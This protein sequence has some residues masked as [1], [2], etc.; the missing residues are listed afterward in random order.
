MSTVPPSYGSNLPATTLDSLMG[1][2]EEEEG[3]GALNLPG[4]LYMDSV[5][6]PTIGYGF[7]L[8]QKNSL[9]A[10]L[11]V[12]QGSFTVKGVTTTGNVFSA[13]AAFA[14]ASSVAVPSTSAIVNYFYW[15][16]H[17]YPSNPSVN[18]LG[19][20]QTQLDNALQDFFT[21]AR[22]D[23][24][25]VNGAPQL[26]APPTA[27]SGVVFEFSNTDFS[28]A[29][30]VLTELIE[31][32]SIPEQTS[33]ALGVTGVSPALWAA[34]AN[35][36]APLDTNQNIIGAGP[37]S[38]QWI[39][40]VLAAYN[41]F[42]LHASDG[43][44]NM[45]PAQSWYSLRYTDN[46]L[47]TSGVA[48]RDYIEST[49][50]GLNGNQSAITYNLALQDYQ[51][52]AQHR[53]TIIPFEQKWGV[54]PDGT[55]PLSVPVAGTAMA[56]ADGDISSIGTSVFTSELATV[57][58]SLT[59]QQVQTLAQ[60][61]N[62]AAEQV[63][64]ELGALYPSIL[65]N[66][67]I[68]GDGPSGAFNVRSTDIFI[69]GPSSLVVNASLGDV[70]P[71]TPT[72]SLAGSFAEASS[73]HILL[74]TGS[75]DTLIGGF[76][77]DILIADTG[78]ETLTSGLGSDTIIA[79]AGTDIVNLR[80]VAST[81]DFE[82]QGQT[83]LNETINAGSFS[84]GAVDVGGTRLTGS[85]GAPTAM[86][87]SPT[88]R[89]DLTWTDAG[90]QTYI[91]DEATHSLGISGGLLGS[92]TSG[93]SITI[94][95]F[96]LAAAEGLGFLGITLAKRV[97]L[98]CGTTSGATS[99][100]EPLP[101][102]FRA[103]S[104]QTYTLST[105][106]ASDAAQTV[107]LTLSGMNPADFRAIVDNQTVQQN[108]DGTFTFVLPAGQTSRLVFADQHGRCRK[109]RQSSTERSAI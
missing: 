32:A 76:G 28:A 47:I 72:A 12:M 94:N 21:G 29:Q 83:G 109:Q 107:T 81:V 88:G 9:G 2:L 63:T 96:N 45:D 69:A 90:G 33:G 6:H 51:M 17:Q 13:V 18:S 91:Y 104:T 20:L 11:D 57:P 65:P 79:G 74:G 14:Q 68:V 48:K 62:P 42:P 19:G 60:I 77:N 95:N 73:N 40:L 85:Q 5:D 16:V 4:R 22:P 89:Y 105:D 108:G 106:T 67:G 98:N 7:D 8:T 34:F 3:Y 84:F 26:P 86:F 80:S 35:N 97:V 100:E 15:I 37:D 36:N 99:G 39:A 30:Q 23:L 93:D 38:Q 75:G 52:L 41:G 87:I 71:L 31:G 82:F 61:F 46:G 66:I 10:V 24:V 102:N 43:V 54:D 56:N 58:A 92:G 53:S 50:F 27:P 25:M 44:R 49:I 64:S 78:N 55:N 103:G 59:G 70:G 101:P 1:V